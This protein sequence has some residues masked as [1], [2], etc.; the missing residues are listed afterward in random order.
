MLE[1]PHESNPKRIVAASLGGIAALLMLP[2]FMPSMGHSHPSN[3]E[4]ISK[5]V[6]LGVGTGLAVGC[7][8][9]SAHP[10]L[11]FLGAITLCLYALLLLLILS[12][13][14]DRL[15]MVWAYWRTIFTN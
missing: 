10:L 9:H 14:I 7:V 5:V 2:W 11:I 4:I 13:S 8:R 1:E 3:A 12:G 15:D 6:M